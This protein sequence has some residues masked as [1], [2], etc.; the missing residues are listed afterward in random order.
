MRVQ[1]TRGVLSATVGVQDAAAVSGGG[2]AGTGRGAGSQSTLLTGQVT[3]GTFPAS[4]GL[5]VVADLTSIGGSAT[6]SFTDGGGGGM[7]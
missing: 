1:G 3:A 2:S 4:T 6:Q 5:A 7:F